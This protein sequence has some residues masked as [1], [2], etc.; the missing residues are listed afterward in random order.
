MGWDPL[1]KLA[2]QI[3]NGPDYEF[4][5]RYALEAEM[6]NVAVARISLVVGVVGSIS[7]A[8]VWVG[9]L[10]LS[11]ARTGWVQDVQLVE[12]LAKGIVVTN[13]IIYALHIIVMKELQKV[14]KVMKRVGDLDDG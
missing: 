12:G 14:G 8:L 7:L 13:A 4:R 9:V 6:L 5:G 1:K 2:R 10:M 11:A 3:L